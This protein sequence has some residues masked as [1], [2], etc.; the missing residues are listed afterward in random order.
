MNHPFFN[1]YLRKIK[2]LL[3]TVSFERFTSRIALIHKL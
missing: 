2:Y 1:D 3:K